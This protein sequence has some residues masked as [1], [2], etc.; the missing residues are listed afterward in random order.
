MYVA[1][2][3]QSTLPTCSLVSRVT[4]K[5]RVKTRDLFYTLPIYRF[6]V[7]YCDSSSNFDST[8]YAKKASEHRIGRGMPHSL[9]AIYSAR[10]ALFVH[11][12]MS[13]K[14]M[15]EVRPV[16]LVR[17]SSTQLVMYSLDTCVRYSTYIPI[18]KSQKGSMEALNFLIISS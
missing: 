8:I 17:E 12:I 13:A 11:G 14:R 6:P 7:H 10:L 9:R 1:E 18:F 16:V 2:E 4:I 3:N 5:G 15:H